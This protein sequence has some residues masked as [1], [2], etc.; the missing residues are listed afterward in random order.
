[1]GLGD[2]GGTEAIGGGAG[3]YREER[4]NGRREGYREQKSLASPVR[5]VGYAFT[6]IVFYV[7]PVIPREAVLEI[8]E[9]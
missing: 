2:G 3:E 7:E 8:S 5:K 9:K 4:G 6:R 1:M